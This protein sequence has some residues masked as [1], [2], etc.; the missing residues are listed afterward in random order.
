MFFISLHA[1]GKPDK[2]YRLRNKKAPLAIVGSLKMK[3]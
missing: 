1:I 2:G 3:E